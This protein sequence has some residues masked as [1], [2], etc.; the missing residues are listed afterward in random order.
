MSIAGRPDLLQRKALRRTARRL[1]GGLSEKFSDFCPGRPSH[2]PLPQA[3]LPRAPWQVVRADREEADTPRSRP[4][5]Q[6]GQG[7]QAPPSSGGGRS[8]SRADVEAVGGDSGGSTPFIQE[9]ARGV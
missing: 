1:S 5:A 3:V 7:R 4:E 2:A 9:P 6:A 8:L